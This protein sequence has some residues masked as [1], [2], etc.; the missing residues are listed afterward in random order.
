MLLAMAEPREIV[1]GEFGLALTMTGSEWDASGLTLIWDVPE[2][3][4]LKIGRKG[5]LSM[6]ELKG[7]MAEPQSGR[8]TL[9]LI[10][11]FP[12]AKVEF[13]KEEELSVGT[14]NLMSGLS[15]E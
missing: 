1:T 4:A 15:A 8:T 12:F 13:E 5:A 14:E 10:K 2:V 9:R 3:G 6:K 11:A 7:L